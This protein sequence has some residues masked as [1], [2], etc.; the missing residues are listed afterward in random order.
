MTG[1]TSILLIGIGNPGRQDDGLGPACAGILERDAV[2]HLKVEANYQLSVED[3]E[4]IARHRTVIFADAAV[5]GPEPFAFESVTPAVTGSFTSHI[6]D[7]QTVMALARE[8]FNAETEAWAMKIRGYVFDEF[9]EN[10]SQRAEQN[11][12]A[13]AAFIRNFVISRRECCNS[14]GSTTS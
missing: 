13:A 5:E 1:Q 11:L 3:A 2:S 4:E 12:A 6:L 7:P 9:G 8:L 10:M 14:T